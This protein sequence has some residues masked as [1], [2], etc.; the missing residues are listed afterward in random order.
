MDLLLED[1]E[2]YEKLNPKLWSEDNK[3]LPEVSEK[4]KEIVSQFIEEIRDNDIPLNVLDAQLVGSNASFNYTKDSDL[5]VHV[6]ADIEDAS[7]DPALLAI[8]YTYFK[9]NFNE[10]YNISIHGVPIEL[11]VE[12]INSLAV[13]NGRY[14]VYRDEWIKFPEIQDIPEFD[15][16]KDIEPYKDRYDQ[17]IADRDGDAAERFWDSLKLLRKDSI[18]VDGEYSTGN[19]I[20]KE[21]RSRGWI[22]RLKEL[23]NSEKSKELSLESLRESK[24]GNSIKLT[25]AEGVGYHYGDLGKAEY[26]YNKYGYPTY[27]GRHTGGWGTGIYFVGTP[28]AGRKDGMGYKDRPE[29][30]IDLSP[31]KLLTPTSNENAYRLHDALLYINNWNDPIPKTW[32]EI[33]NEYDEMYDKVFP[34]FR[35]LNDDDISTDV[36]ID[37]KYVLDYIKKYSRH[38]PDKLTREDIEDV[39]T[40]IDIAQD[41]RKALGDESLEFERNFNRLEDALFR[42]RIYIDKNKLRRI[43][44]DA[45]NSSSNEAPS[46]LIIKALGYDGIDTRHLSKDADGLSGLD[47][48]GFGSVVFDLKE[49]C[50]LNE[51][52]EQTGRTVIKAIL[53]EAK[54]QPKQPVDD[55]QD[56]EEDG[57]YKLDDITYIAFEKRSEVDPRG[58]GLIHEDIKDHF[59]VKAFPDFKDNN[60]IEEAVEFDN[61]ISGASIDYKKHLYNDINKKLVLGHFFKFVAT[62]KKAVSEYFVL[63]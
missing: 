51:T 30:K 36:K 47:N 39:W 27:G 17:I 61:M 13:S 19:L 35:D 55:F 22:E 32:D 58:W 52:V 45:L 20:F 15:I 59:I 42:S 2:K 4:I 28:I 3:L 40:L 10:K 6:V 8:L 18:A 57:L 44:S 26:R 1:L 43:V 31:Y 38:Y 62:I 50:R 54:D 60:Y 16:S 53:F 34:G 9:N 12:D 11:Y 29:H 49:S 25:E 24:Q 23:I 37:K 48:F 63:D 46:T 41:I 14:S 5:D 7:C 21:F 56:F 33:Y